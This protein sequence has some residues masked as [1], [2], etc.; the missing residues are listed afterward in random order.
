MNAGGN[1]PMAPRPDVTRGQLTPATEDLSA[2]A[3]AGDS[4]TVL[5]FAL[6]SGAGCVVYEV[7]NL[8]EPA[9]F[10]FPGEPTAVNRALDDAGFQAGMLT[11]AE[12]IPH[13]ASWAD[14]IAT[15]LGT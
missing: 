5:A 13:D 3:V 7:L 9:T 1:R 10:V 8:P 12:P 6:G 15:V 4:P 14:R 11:A 2:L